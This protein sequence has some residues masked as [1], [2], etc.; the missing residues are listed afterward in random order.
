MTVETDKCLITYSM[1]QEAAA[2][3]SI[4]AAPQIVHACASG[5]FGRY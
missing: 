4:I 3:I 5:C 2:V 1:I